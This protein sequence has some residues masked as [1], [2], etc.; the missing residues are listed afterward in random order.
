MRKQRISGPQVFAPRNPH[1]PVSRTHMQASSVMEHHIE[2][3][4]NLS[5]HRTTCIASSLQKKSKYKELFHGLGG[6]SK[7]GLSDLASRTYVLGHYVAITL[8]VRR[9]YS[10][11]LLLY[12][13]PVFHT[14]FSLVSLTSSVIENKGIPWTLC[15]SPHPGLCLLQLQG[16]LDTYCIHLI[17]P[18]QNVGMV[19][20]VCCLQC[21]EH[22]QSQG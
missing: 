16:S 22:I 13:S 1:V 5:T 4:V 8:Y 3:M 18:D 20:L 10:L 19:S 12:W 6:P 15:E 17:V 2:N 21:L 9:T 14:A 11:N 7:S